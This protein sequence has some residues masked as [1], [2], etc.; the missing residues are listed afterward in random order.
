MESQSPTT[1]LQIAM[2]PFLAIG[3]ITPFLHLANKLAKLGH[4]VSFLVPTKTQP[5]IQHLN[6]FP[7]PIAFV[8]V[9]V[10]HVDRLPHGAKTTADVAAHQI[11]LIGTAMD[12]TEPEVENIL[13]R[14][15]PDIVFFDLAHWLPKVARSLGVK[16]VY[17]C[18]ASP[19]M[20]AYLSGYE[21]TSSL[22]VEQRL[23]EPPPGFPDPSIKLRRHEIPYFVE[24]D[25]QLSGNGIKL[26][27]RIHVS[28]IECDAFASKG[29]QE[30]E[31]PFFDFLKERRGWEISLTGM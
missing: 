12:R 26:D 25:S 17:F 20:I 15:K 3:H 18:T 24:I 11:P 27:D 23:L 30:L 19:V 14:I 6:L 5:K 29:C 8:P 16:T 10:P 21:S 7:R 4:R 31:G 9:T 28:V 2:S 13:S 22:P 1:S